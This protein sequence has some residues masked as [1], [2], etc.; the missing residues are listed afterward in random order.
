[1]PKLKVLS[2][3]DIIKILQ[4][5]NFIIERQKGSHVKL[6]RIVKDEDDDIEQKLTVPNHKELD[7]GTVKAIYNQSLKYISE[8]ELKKYFYSK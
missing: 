5:F 6:A 4:G 2:G 3:Q 1:M 8:S 7:K